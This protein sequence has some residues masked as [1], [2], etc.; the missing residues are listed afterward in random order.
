MDVGNVG[1]RIPVRK[2]FLMAL[3]QD[4]QNEAPKWSTKG[5]DAAADP[6]PWPAPKQAAP[7]P[8]GTTPP[9]RAIDLE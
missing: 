8:I 5:F 9:T 2:Y 7:K 6:T 1:I 4:F 3:K